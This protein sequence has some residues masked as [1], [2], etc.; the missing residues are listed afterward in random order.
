MRRLTTTVLFAAML[1][2]ALAQTRPYRASYTVRYATNAAGVAECVILSVKVTRSGVPAVVRDVVIDG[3]QFAELTGRWTVTGPD[4]AKLAAIDAAA[5]VI[6]NRVV[7]E[8]DKR[9]NGRKPIFPIS[10]TREISTDVFT[11][12]PGRERNQ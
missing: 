5:E 1:S 9:Q 6:M 4:A 3:Q 7:A 11:Q 12:T 8:E 2:P 10:L